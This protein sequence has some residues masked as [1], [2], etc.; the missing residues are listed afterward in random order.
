ML[1]STAL[2]MLQTA[3]CDSVPVALGD[4]GA[5]ASSMLSSDNLLTLLN[6]LPGAAYHCEPG[7][8]WRILFLHRPTG[9]GLRGR[10]GSVG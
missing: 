2:K 1:H 5:T 3:A 6:N 10:S 8:P 7:L 9:G 4:V